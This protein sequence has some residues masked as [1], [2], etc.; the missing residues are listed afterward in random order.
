MEPLACLRCADTGNPGVLNTVAS[1]TASSW[2]TNNF[3]ALAREASEVTTRFPEPNVKPP[4]KPIVVGVV[5][6]CC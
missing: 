2:S 6:G 3:A 1:L 4:L 5:T